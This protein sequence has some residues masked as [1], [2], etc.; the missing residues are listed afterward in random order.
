LT[1]LGLRLMEAPAMMV[2]VEVSVAVNT[3]EVDQ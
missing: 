2:L 1:V 3:L